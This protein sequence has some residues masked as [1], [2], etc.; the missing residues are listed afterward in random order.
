MNPH[1]HHPGTQ[2]G[3][4]LVTHNQSPPTRPGDPPRRC[5]VQFHGVRGQSDFRGP[6]NG[7]PWMPW[8]PGS[9]ETKVFAPQ[10]ILDGCVRRSFS[11][12]VS[13]GVSTSMLVYPCLC[14]YI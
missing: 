9:G 10:Q 8:M 7:A 5:G 1:Q 11:K 4:R 13:P 6:G 14:I 2:C 12:R 3:Y